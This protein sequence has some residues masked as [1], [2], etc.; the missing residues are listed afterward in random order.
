VEKL[1]LAVSRPVTRVE[2]EPLAVVKD[3]AVA[4]VFETRVLKEPLALTSEEAVASV[5]VTRTDNELDAAVR[6]EAV[7]SEPLILLE[8]DEENALKDDV[9]KNAVLSRSSSKSALNA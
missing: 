6:T 3:E 5:L 2:N 1:P 4:S 7:T 8:Y 9:Y